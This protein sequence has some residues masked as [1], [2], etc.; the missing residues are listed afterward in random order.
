MENALNTGVLGGAYAHGLKPRSPLD[1]AVSRRCCV[2]PTRRAGAPPAGPPKSTYHPL[3]PCCRR[4][5]VACV[6]INT[7]IYLGCVN[8]VL[9]RYQ[10][11]DMCIFWFYQHHG[12]AFGLPEN[13]ILL[14]TC[15]PIGPAGLRY[16]PGVITR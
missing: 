9:S 2:V 7:C 4:A 6:V 15:W 11:H 13:Q 1:A 5:E 3:Y 8:I 14:V 16:K 12:I 10:Y